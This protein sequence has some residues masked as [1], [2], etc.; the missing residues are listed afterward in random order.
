MIR[1]ALLL[2]ALLLATPATARPSDEATIRTLERDWRDARIRGDAGWLERFY[3]P[4]L[5]IQG[6]NGDVSTR[7]YDIALFRNR[8]VRPELIEPS[9]MQVR[10]YGATAVV[11]GIDHMRGSY[12]GHAG[13]LWLRFTDVLVRRAGRWQLVIQQAT[14]AARP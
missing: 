3:A 1:V 2:P 7:A 10:L 12:K 14:P 8:E 11:T 4:E 13:E 9:D 6:M 5:T